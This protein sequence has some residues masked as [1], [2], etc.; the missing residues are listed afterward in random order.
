MHM[1]I[2]WNNTM[3]HTCDF[4][5]NTLGQGK[6]LIVVVP[7]N[8]HFPPQKVFCFGP[9]HFPLPG[10]SSLALYLNLYFYLKVWLLRHPFP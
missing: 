3:N 10:N 6:L 5:Q 9:H 1:V 2:F 4:M 7:E 8:M